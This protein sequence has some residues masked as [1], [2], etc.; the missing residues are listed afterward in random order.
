MLPATGVATWSQ[1]HLRS[2]PFLQVRTTKKE[3]DRSSARTDWSRPAW[4]GLFQTGQCQK[5]IWMKRTDFLFAHCKMRRCRPLWSV[6]LGWCG[7][8][9]G[10]EKWKGN[11]SSENKKNLPIQGKSSR[12]HYYGPIKS[13][14]FTYSRAVYYKDSEVQSLNHKQQMCLIQSKVV[15]RIFGTL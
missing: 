6:D 9:T 13:T 3:S 7:D 8:K 1:H 10:S 12:R 14:N 4:V 2:D 15:N 11:I 5:H